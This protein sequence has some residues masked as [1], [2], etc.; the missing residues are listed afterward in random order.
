MTRVTFL[1]VLIWGGLLLGL[2]LL[3][4]LLLTLLIPLVVYVLAGLF[5]S[6]AQ[7]QFQMTRWV[8]TD[9]AAPGEQVSIQLNIQNKGTDQEDLCLTSFLP[10]GLEALEGESEFALFLPR[11]KTIEIRHTVTGQRGYYGLPDLSITS[12]DPFDLFQ[13]QTRMPAPG[14]VFF[15]PQT[16]PLK[17]IA[18]RPNRT[19][20]FSGQ[21]P[22]RI[23]GPG[24]EFFGLRE[25][26][27]GD[28]L[29]WIDWNTTARHTN[30]LFTKIFEQERV[31][32]VGLI[33]DARRRSNVKYADRSL[34]EHGVV[35]TASL[36][37]TFLR[38]GNRVGLLLYGSLLDWT[39]PAY[40]KVQR[41]RIMRSLAR[42]TLGDSLV[43]GSMENL[44]TRL[45]PSNSQLVIISPLMDGD[46][47][48]LVGLRARGYQIL[49]IS[50]NPISFERPLLEDNES[51]ALAARIAA[52]E[53]RLLLGKLRQAGIFVM[54]WDVN[55]TFENAAHASLHNVPLSYQTAG[56]L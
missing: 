22:A 11:D 43:F 8:N 49:V 50:P 48:M 47:R 2:G 5:F 16:P 40:G 44:P 53:R 18:I 9:R 32:D 23:G 19:R 34:F 12:R 20:T 33:L 39:Y 42:A 55:V 27:T 28:S 35:A 17:R 54:D 25:Y 6:P 30:L 14:R 15:I 7:P 1:G 24:V 51:V 36:A 46:E 41:E 10:D 13:R 26:Q 45:F 21:V 29:R 38:T 4:G 52:V 3:N 37:E 31:V 56:L